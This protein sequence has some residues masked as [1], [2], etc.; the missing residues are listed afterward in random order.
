VSA[1]LLALLAGRQQARLLR[2]SFPHDD[3]PAAPLLVERLQAD[4]YLSK[5]FRFTVELLSDDARIPL[6]AL[7]GKLMCV[8]LVQAGGTLRSFTGHVQRFKHVKTDGGFAYYRAVLVPW[9]QYLQLRRNQRL[10][11]EQTLYDQAREIFG[12][13]GALPVWDWKIK[14]EQPRLT[15]TTQWAESDHNYLSARWEAAGYSYR[16]E[17]DPKGH[18]LVVQDDTRDAEPIDGPA[19]EIRFQAQGGSADEDAIAQWRAERR[20][21]SG[22][23]AL[24]GYDFK[25]PQPLHAEVPTLNRQG[26]IP[27][28]EVHAYEGHY[29]FKHRSGAD[30]LVRQRMEEIE[31]R[32][33]RFEAEGNNRR[34]APGRWFRLAEHYLY[35]PEP[36]FL[37]LEAHHEARNNYLQGADAPAAYSNRFVCQPLDLPW[38]PGRGFNSQPARLLELQTAT[39]VGP[40]G[41]GSLNIDAYGRVRLQFHWDRLATNSC[42][43]R[44]ASHWAGAT[45][46]A[47]S[48]PRVGS[49]VI[50]QWLDG[51]P[52]HPIVTGCVHNQ[53]HMPPWQ[54]P[55]QQALSGVRS[56]ELKP[57]GTG[58][59]NH[60]VFDD[61]AGKIQVQLRS[62]HQASQLSLGHITRIEDVAGRKEARGQGF[63]LR[64]DGQGSVR[65]QRG[66]LISTEPRP[67]ARAH[68]TDMAETLQRLKDG[69]A[70]HHDLSDA[71]R[72]AKAHEAGDQD[73]VVQALDAQA[74]GLS[75]GSGNPATGDFPEYAS[76]QLTL[77]SPAG[78]QASVEG[79]SHVASTEHNA[80]TSGGHTSVSAGKSLLV[81]ARNAVR[82]FAYQAGMKL[83]AASADIDI[84]ALKHSIHLLAKLDIT[85]TANRITLSAKEEITING[86]TSFSRWNASGITHG[87]SGVWKQQAGDHQAS[88]P[89][90]EGSPSLPRAEPLPRGQ[91][92]LLH[93]YIDRAGAKRQPVRQG[94]YSVTDAEGGVHEGVLDA[95]GFASLAGLPMGTALVRYGDDPRD[96]WD[97]ASYLGQPA[98][99]PPSPANGEDG[100]SA[101][102]RTDGRAEAALPGGARPGYGAAALSAIGR[103]MTGPAQAAGRLAAAAEAAT[104]ALSAARALRQGGAQALLGPASEL[105]RSAARGRPAPAAALP[106][107]LPPGT[108]SR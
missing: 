52:D 44:V 90:S 48:H 95:N 4:E 89:A 1:T 5:D 77:A 85:H 72:L 25:S 47:S 21:A 51:N 23:A 96:P 29:G 64:T 22:R 6:E 31:A 67:G 71:A 106:P 70:L 66:L 79:S 26:D 28:L 10:F 97:E 83:L 68:V 38:R 7:Q 34:V 14:G 100:S 36:A 55:G 62:D 15:M 80:F 20:W 74:Q 43:V 57:G 65:A 102:E 107:L 61:T 93:H 12:D 27:T 69:Q 81:S 53:R 103:G 9:L 60:L 101:D 24:S 39:V 45:Q 46:G 105:A 8:S 56:R 30:R 92:D 87:T 32:G 37:I 76:P 84:S 18:R 78:L 88:G 2:L 58:R 86:G 82:L 50:V 17:H 73:T 3:G 11:H 59:S 54:L 104:Q 41:E 42:W 94:S 13:Y 91:L 98:W 35:G 108:S 16:Y 99:P 49:E 40:D 63:E 75:S 19:P 33:L